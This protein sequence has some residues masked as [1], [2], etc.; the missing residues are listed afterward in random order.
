MKK[1][2]I[3]DRVVFYSRLLPTYVARDDGISPASGL[4]VQGKVGKVGT[5]GRSF[6]AGEDPELLN[7][8]GAITRQ[9]GGVICLNEAHLTHYEMALFYR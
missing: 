7:S 6:P 9:Q 8:E 5:H 4:G 1:K 2:S 3:I